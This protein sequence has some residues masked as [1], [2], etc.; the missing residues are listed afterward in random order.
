MS[1]ENFT[2]TDRLFRLSWEA[3]YFYVCLLIRT[4]NYFDAVKHAVEN[5]KNKSSAIKEVHACISLYFRRSVGL[6]RT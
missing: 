3:Q 4:G 1:L 5:A 2:C 6:W